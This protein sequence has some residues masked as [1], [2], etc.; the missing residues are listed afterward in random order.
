[1]EV[2]PVV[3]RLAFS[4]VFLVQ[5]LHSLVCVAAH[6]SHVRVVEPDVARGDAERGRGTVEHDGLEPVD[7]QPRVAPLTVA[8]QILRQVSILAAQTSV[9]C[10]VREVP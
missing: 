4:A 1:M 3:S 8:N 5:Q 9:L 2:L 7:R 6:L 10:L